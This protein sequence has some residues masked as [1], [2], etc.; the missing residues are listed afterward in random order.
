MTVAREDPDAGDRDSEDSPAGDRDSEDSPAGGDIGD[1]LDVEDRGDELDVGDRNDDAPSP[2]DE[3]ADP[4]GETGSTGGPGGRAGPDSPFPIDGTPLRLAAAKA[5]VGPGR[6]VPLLERVQVD[7][8]PRLDDYRQRFE[9]VHED[10]ERAVFLVP[11]DHWETVG[12]RLGLDRRER[13]AI[14][15][16][17]NEQLGRLGSKA[18]RREEFDTALEIRDAVVVGTG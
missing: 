10:D 16:A 18:D 6:V 12:D 5:S 15:R 4:G 3:S 14:R 13:D 9:C 8:A 17:H 11:E 2:V 1:E 7:L